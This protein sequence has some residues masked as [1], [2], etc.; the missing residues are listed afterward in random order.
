MLNS[1]QY[2]AHGKIKIKADSWN[3]DADTGTAVAHHEMM[4]FT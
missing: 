2:T 4:C 1:V 3:V